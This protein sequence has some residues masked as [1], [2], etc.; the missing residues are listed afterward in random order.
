MKPALLAFLWLLLIA[1][2]SAQNPPREG[3]P[4]PLPTI[5][6]RIEGM[7]SY[8][9]FFTD[10]WDAREGKLW[11]R[12]DRWNAPFLFHE[13]LPNG[14][15]SN[16]IGPGPRPGGQD[17]SGPLRAFERVIVLENDIRSLSSRPR[18]GPR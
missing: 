3:Q 18:V 13:S 16:D 8:A 1:S 4:K 17:V 5:A 6:Q 10:Y 12:V 9:G 15:G 14:V 11:L 7:Q 2:V